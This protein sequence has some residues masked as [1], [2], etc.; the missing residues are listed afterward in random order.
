MISLQSIFIILTSVLTYESSVFAAPPLFKASTSYNSSISSLL[1][2]ISISAV[3]VKNLA[4]YVQM[5]P[6]QYLTVLYA[7]ENFAFLQAQPN[8]VHLD[9][10]FSELSDLPIN[11]DSITIPAVSIPIPNPSANNPTPQI[12]NPNVLIFIVHPGTRFTWYNGE[13]PQPTLPT[14][15][16]LTANSNIT[17]VFRLSLGE[18]NSRVSSAAGSTPGVSF[19][20]IPN[21]APDLGRPPLQ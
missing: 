19:T 16:Q 7:H 15:F 12:P 2:P 9:S 5:S 1:Q 6:P 13:G 10:I 3:T 18:L 4:P 8:E 11:S 20:P 14:G 21:A 17:D